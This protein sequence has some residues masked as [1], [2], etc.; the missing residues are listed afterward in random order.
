MK[1][2]ESNINTKYKDIING[3]CVPVCL[4]CFDT[5]FTLI[6]CLLDL[7]LV[8][9]AFARLRCVFSRHVFKLIR[10][11]Y[12]TNHPFCWT[13]IYILVSMCVCV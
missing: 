7:L 1:I 11:V 5:G 2:Y 9:F 6:L 4:A 10:F 3:C 13:Y 12:C 8:P